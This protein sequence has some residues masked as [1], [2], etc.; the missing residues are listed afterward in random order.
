M[1]FTSRVFSMIV[2]SCLTALTL[3]Q[4]IMAQSDELSFAISFSD[5]HFSPNNLA[6]PANKKFLLKVT[7]SGKETIEFESFKLNRETPIEPG[8]TVEV[9]LPALSS[10]SYDFYDDFHPNVPEGQL[11]AK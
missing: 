7:N 9:Y 2:L 5:G 11:I 8:K 3:P 1:F 6:V 10:G 4:R